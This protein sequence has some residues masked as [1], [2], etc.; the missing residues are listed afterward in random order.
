MSVLPVTGPVLIVAIVMTV[1]LVAP[2]LLRRVRMPGAVGLIL[3]GVLI[4]PN[5]MGLLARDA[6]IVL[7]G[8]MGLLYIMFVAGL[9][10]NL[11]QFKRH[12]NKSIGFGLMTFLL[13]MV[14]GTALGSILLN[15]PLPSAILLGSVFASHTL[16]AY[17][18]ATRL[19]IAKNN[20]VTTAVGAT[21]ITDTLALLVLAIIAGA[22][23]GEFGP[24]FL[25]Q[26][27]VP[28]LALS[29]LTMWG[30]PR[31][32]AWF[33]RAVGGE[34][35]SSFVFILAA[36][37]ACAAMM[38][39]IGI[40]AIIGAFLAGLALNRLV[41]EHSALMNRISFFGDA[42]FIPFF[43]ISTGMLVDFRVLGTNVDAWTVAG[44]MIAA[45]FIAKGGASYAAMAIYRYSWAEAGVMFGLTIPQAAATLAAVLI[46]YELELF[47]DA[48]LNGTILMILVTCIAGPWLTERFGR[49]VRLLEES[50]PIDPAARPERILVPM[51]NPE[52]AKELVELALLL[53]SPSSE[54]PIYPLVVAPSGGDSEAQVAAAER[55]LETAVVHAAAADV[56]SVPIT[57]LDHNIA[58]GIVRAVKEQR[59]SLVVIGWSGKATPGALVFGTVLDQLLSE[60]N[61]MIAVMRAPQPVSSPKRMV[62]ALPPLI[63]REP[64]F[65]GAMRALRVFAAQR[66]MTVLAYAAAEDAQEIGT[67]MA[68]SLQETP[69]E[70]VKLT[71]WSELLE[72]LDKAIGPADVIVLPS[73]RRG[74]LAWRP[75]LDRLPRLLA[76]RFDANDL[77]TLYLSEQDVSSIADLSD[78]TPGHGAFLRA[79]NITVGLT[80][81]GDKALT[82]VLN[83]GLDERVAR[84]VIGQINWGYD[85]ADYAPE[86]TPGVVFFH[87][88]TATVSEP[89]LLVGVSEN[90]VR[91]RR[92]GSATFVI[93]IFL[94]PTEMPSGEYLD[95]L[96]TIAHMIRRDGIVERLR[97]APNARAVEATLVGDQ[98]DESAE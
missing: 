82:Q 90:G 67:L 57:R 88:H 63:H 9:E 21:I 65:G 1:I 69:L 2:L 48:I 35:V 19:G 3:A 98:Y 7:L 25:L 17:P 5:A 76:G 56:Q 26:L 78:Q 38:E 91:L 43:L 32:G 94:A 44:T 8:T 95:R 85:R 73:V 61:T 55:L 22:T 71:A 60:T 28:L 27:F 72:S 24:V 53:R 54:D 89:M 86:I 52:T 29:A 46:G 39:I 58:M 97:E 6:T 83:A 37:F 13:P 75:A 68:Q 4:G 40:E 74:A 77:L 31:L 45:V 79:E 51:A 20:A 64:G 10:I 23:G 49:P 62:V 50:R 92:T 18:I 33:F 96:A 12:K 11:H 47:D 84:D 70:I 14:L 41:P 81:D 93:M 80:E 15:L 66:K 59:I 42:F 30:L 36:V 16:L 34:G 87:A